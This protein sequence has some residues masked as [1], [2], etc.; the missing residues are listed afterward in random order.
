T[1]NVL[2]PKYMQEF[3]CI[4]SACED[5]CCTGWR[6]DVDRDTYKKYKKTS[7]IELK[8]LLEK[9]ITR[10]RSNPS[11]TTYAK[12]KMDDSGN[13]SL[14][15]EE[16]L[17]KIQLKLGEDYLSNTCSIYPRFVNRV[18]GVIEKSAT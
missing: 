6:V 8:P 17:C 5:T 1:R 9:N 3:T 11:I 2:I 7:D 4:G 18:N 14:L 15:T 13:C 12:I 16:K 10:N